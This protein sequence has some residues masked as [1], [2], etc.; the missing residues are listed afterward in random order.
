MY[1]RD[2]SCASYRDL[3]LAKDADVFEALDFLHSCRAGLEENEK[4]LGLIRD[5]HTIWADPAHRAKMPPTHVFADPFHIFWSNGIISAELNLF[6]GRLRAVTKDIAFF[7]TALERIPF[8]KPGQGPGTASLK[9][10]LLEKMFGGTFYKGCAR[11]T[12]DVLV[13]VWYGIQEILAGQGVLELE[14]SSMGAAVHLARHLRRITH[15]GR[16]PIIYSN[17][18]FLL[19]L[20]I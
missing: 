17:T 19:L 14:I 15:Q 3:A 12:Q 4:A 11:Q 8:E 7:L 18:F 1:F 5:E 20:P 16:L 6:M 2:I 13:L 10:L 9:A